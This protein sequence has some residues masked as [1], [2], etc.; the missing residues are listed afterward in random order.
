M[1]ASMRVPKITGQ[2]CLRIAAFVVVLG[3]GIFVAGTAT[4]ADPPPKP[5]YYDS[6]TAASSPAGGRPPVPAASASGVIPPPP[7]ADSSA[8]LPDPANE[9]WLLPRFERPAAGTGPINPWIT[10]T[11][12]PPPTPLNPPQPM[13]PGSTPIPLVGGPTTLPLDCPPNLSGEP[14]RVPID[15]PYALRLANAANP[16]IAIARTRIEEAYARQQQANVLWVPD[17]WLGGNPEGPFFL[18][19]YSH[20]DGNIQNTDGSIIN[21]TKSNFSLMA[22]ASLNFNL[23]DAFF[24]PRVARQATAAASFRAVA[25]TSDIQL[26]VALA[27]LDL[28]RAYGALAINAETISKAKQM[29]NFALQAERSGLG[30]TT[31]DANRARVELELRKQERLDLEGQAALASAQL[32]QLLVLDSAVDLLPADR[33]VLPISLVNTNVRIDELVAVG[34]L[35]RP[36]LAESRALVQQALTEWRANRYR[37]L[38]PTL[39][40]FY[41]GASFQGGSPGLGNTGGRDEFVAQAAWELKNGGL[42]DLFRAKESRI[43]YNGATLHVIEVQAQVGAEVAAAAKLAQARQRSLV[44]AQEAVRQ[45]EEMWARLSRAAFGFGTGPAARFDPLE[46]LVAEQQLNEAR[47]SY[48][49]AVIDYNRF[50]FRLFWAMGSPAMEALPVAVPLAVQM[51]VVPSHAQQEGRDLGQGGSAPR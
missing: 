18:P 33:A 47:F 3:F 1:E 15:L 8:P 29:Y 46:A 39:Q 34:L 30:K 36:E 25:T 12:A 45:A 4:W 10:P 22:G 38:I 13:A 48:L 37:P 49:N 23:G 44:A 41:Y 2:T 32:A 28:L 11:G 14:N 43:R 24:A 17:F 31:A 20:H 9:A 51:P 35:N 6:G 27:Y 50:Q 5:A 16:T 19:M 26:N 21:V 40:L 42:G 7:K